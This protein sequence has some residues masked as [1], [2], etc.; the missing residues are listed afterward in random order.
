MTKFSDIK[1]VCGIQN[2]AREREK[3][4]ERESMRAT[5]T[6][7]GTLKIIHNK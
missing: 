3:E 1:I 5:I 2:R 7:R 6:Q 4:S